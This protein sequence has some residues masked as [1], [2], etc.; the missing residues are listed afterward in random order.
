VLDIGG[1]NV[2]GSYRDVFDDPQWTYHALDVSPGE[3][4]DVVPRKAWRWQDVRARSYDVIVSG[5]AF[6][7]IAF[8]WVTI[9][10]MRRVLRPGGLM[11]VVAP[12]G[13]Q[14]HRYPLDCWRYYRD[15]LVALATWADLEVLDAAVHHDAD[16][17]SDDSGQWADAVLIARRASA[18]GLRGRL[19]EVKREVVRAV[20]AFNAGRRYDDAQRTADDLFA[21][22][23]A[24]EA[25]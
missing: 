19:S 18:T 7:H 15:G 10:E 24:R 23:P 6:E 2:N 22:D 12:S 13:G 5:Q 4:V 17:W 8:P 20:G 16:R 1:A 9:I 14:E 11:C 3:G 21:T 25:Q